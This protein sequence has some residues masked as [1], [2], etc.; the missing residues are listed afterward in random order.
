MS[1]LINQSAVVGL[2]ILFN[3]ILVISSHASLLSFFIIKHKTSFWG[4]RSFWGGGVFKARVPII[5]PENH[6]VTR[7][8]RGRKFPE[9]VLF[10]VSTANFISAFRFLLLRTYFKPPP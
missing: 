4:G 6:A 1:I 2:C 9:F 7:E 10:P 8:V 5:Y 3:I